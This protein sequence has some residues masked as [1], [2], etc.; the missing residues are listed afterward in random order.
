MRSTNR[1]P[2]FLS[3]SYFTG[4]P[5]T[6]TSMI[7]LTLFGGS[8]P[9]GMRSMFI[10]MFLGQVPGVPKQGQAEEQCADARRHRSDRVAG[11]RPVVM[12][13]DEQRRIERKGREGGD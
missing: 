6:G 2:D 13:F 5:P 3:N 9:I 7:T 8:S 11:R 10:A 4:S 12:A 1:A